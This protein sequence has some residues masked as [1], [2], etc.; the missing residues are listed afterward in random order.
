MTTRGLLAGVLFDLLEFDGME[1]VSL[2]QAPRSSTKR[3]L[4]DTS[5]MSTQILQQ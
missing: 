1:L 5:L 3:A 4:G 2:S